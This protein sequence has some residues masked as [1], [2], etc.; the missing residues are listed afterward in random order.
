MPQLITVVRLAPAEQEWLLIFSDNAVNSESSVYLKTNCLSLSEASVCF[1]RF[2]GSLKGA[3]IVDALDTL[4][5]MEMHDEFEEA[6]DWVEK[7]LEFNMVRETGVVLY[8][9]SVI[10]SPLIVYA[11]DIVVGHY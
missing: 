1:S 11:V 4:F 6:T 5:I 3:T 7:N 8:S 9:M 2:L 10:L